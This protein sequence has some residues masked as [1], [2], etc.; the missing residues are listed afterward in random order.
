[1]FRFCSFGGG[2]VALFYTLMNA[3]PD[4]MPLVE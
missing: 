3:G 1:M 4:E 2:D